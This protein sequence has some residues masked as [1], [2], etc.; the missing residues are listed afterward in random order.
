METAG[1]Q[2]GRKSGIVRVKKGHNRNRTV[3]ALFRVSGKYSERKARMRVE[4]VGQAFTDG[5][6]FHR[7]FFIFML[8]LIRR[9][10]IIM[11]TLKLVVQH[12]IKNMI[13]CTT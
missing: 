10:D 6:L 3:V 5:F 11:L 1:R 4:N 13:S 7:I 8:T 2:N 12:S 9:D